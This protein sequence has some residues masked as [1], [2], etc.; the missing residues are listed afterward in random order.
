MTKSAIL[1]HPG[2][3]CNKKNFASHRQNYEQKMQDAQVTKSLQ[4]LLTKG[5]NLEAN[6][7]ESS[8]FCQPLLEGNFA[9]TP[10]W[11]TNPK[12]P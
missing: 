5:C 12:L 8:H 1:L 11:V 9:I 3:R 4:K 7:F 2:T 6:I 10:E